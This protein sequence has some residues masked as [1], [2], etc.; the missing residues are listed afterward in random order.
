M[1]LALLMNHEHRLNFQN[2][3]QEILFKIFVPCSFELRRQEKWHF[4]NFFS[5]V[6]RLRNI[7]AE[8]NFWNVSRGICSKTD[9][10]LK[11]GKARFSRLL[12]YYFTWYFTTSVVAWINRGKTTSIDIWH[13]GLI[14]FFQWITY[15]S[16][17]LVS[18]ERKALFKIFFTPI[19][20][21]LPLVF[22]HVC[23][24]M[25]K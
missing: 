4:P 8:T 25:N 24:H 20:I 10:L 22:Y 13:H 3:R 17:W 6:L 1:T 7:L 15:G 9:C 11:E 14:F 23:R 21:L 19:A 2:D 5:S 18:K 16:E 12:L